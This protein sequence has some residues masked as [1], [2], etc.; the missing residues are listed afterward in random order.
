MAWGICEYE[1][2]NALRAVKL[3][4]HASASIPLHMR[5]IVSI[6]GRECELES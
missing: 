1:V 6:W 5:R 3:S 4:C 2:I